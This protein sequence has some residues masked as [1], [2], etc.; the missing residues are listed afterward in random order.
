[1]TQYRWWAVYTERRLAGEDKPRQCLD[2][3]ALRLSKVIGAGW[4]AAI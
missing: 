1:M 4:L 2:A 3:P